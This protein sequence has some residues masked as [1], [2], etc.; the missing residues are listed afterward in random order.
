MIVVA[1]SGMMIALAIP[2]IDTTKYKADAVAQIIRTTLQNASRTAVTRQHDMIVSFD[3]VGE[4]V[5]Q[6]WDSNNDG[7]VRVSPG[8]PIAGSITESCSR[9]RV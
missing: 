4:R 2:R 5:R 8:S 9:T 1:I 3:T 6:H 7:V